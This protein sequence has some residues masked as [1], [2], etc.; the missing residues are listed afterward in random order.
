MCN[1]NGVFIEI[2]K[3][4][5]FMRKKELLH[6][7]LGR[8]TFIIFDEKGEREKYNL[9]KLC[10]DKN[11][12]FETIEKVVLEPDLD[13]LTRVYMDDV[14][15]F[16]MWKGFRL[17]DYEKDYSDKYEMDD[18]LNIFDNQDEP[19]LQGVLMILNH[20]RYIF[21]SDKK[22]QYIELFYYLASLLQQPSL[23]FPINLF[24]ST[25]GTGKN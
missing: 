6:T 1:A 14:P 10:V 11:S 23:Q 20:M 16:N 22:E 5:Y 25:Q 12:L 2:Y 21:C 9:Y 24:K 18:V 4:T 7:Q 17:V 3:T 15:V 13:K 8:F 19:S